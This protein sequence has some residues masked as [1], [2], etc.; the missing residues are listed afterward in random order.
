MSCIQKAKVQGRR[1]P[2]CICTI[3]H[4]LVACLLSRWQR[5]LKFERASS[6]RCLWERKTHL[7][8]PRLPLT[9]AQKEDQ[10]RDHFTNCRTSKPP[11][12]SSF[13]AWS[14]PMEIEVSQRWTLRQHSCKT[15]CPACSDPIEAVIEV[16]LQ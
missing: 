6:A 7:N 11:P 15:S 13:V 1:L 4:S 9:H 10:R 8:S 5:G 12:P 2:H 3:C 14:D 16:S